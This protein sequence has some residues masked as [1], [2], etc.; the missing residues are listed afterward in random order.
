MKRP[1]LDRIPIPDP[2]PEPGAIYMTMDL[3]QWDAVLE[4]AYNAGA[5]L[6][7]IGTRSGRE[8]VRRAYR[9]THRAN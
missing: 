5:T 8:Y 3:G 2:F 7:E 4:G 1:T 9:Q 6:L